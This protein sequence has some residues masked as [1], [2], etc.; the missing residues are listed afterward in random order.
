MILLVASVVAARQRRLGAVIAVAGAVVLWLRG[1]LVPGTPRFAPRLVEPLPFDFGHGSS[2]DVKSASIVD[3]IDEVPD[4]ERVFDTLFEADVVVAEDDELVL[5]DEFYSAWRSRMATLRELPGPE[6]AARTAA[7]SI[8]D[9]DGEYHGGRV[10]L[11]GSRDVWLRPAVAIA[12]TAAV[13]TLRVR[14]VPEAVAATAARPLREFLGVCPV[15]AGSVTETAV[16]ECC[17]GPGA[18]RRRPDRRVLACVDCDAVVF[19]FDEE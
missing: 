4:P 18:P 8:A 6:L 1:Y 2:D 12:E 7:S 14:D 5:T 9:A 16:Q 13:E 17:G 19:T 11:A 10:L 15:C 3:D